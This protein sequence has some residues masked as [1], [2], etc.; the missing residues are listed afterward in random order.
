MKKRK[1]IASLLS[2]LMLFSLIIPQPIALAAPSGIEVQFNNGN[3]G[4][5]SNTINIKYKVVNTSSSPVNLHS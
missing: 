2:L 5:N 4:T 3:T 1:F